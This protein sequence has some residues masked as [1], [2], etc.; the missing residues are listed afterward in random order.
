MGSGTVLPPS[1][2]RAAWIGR[3][4]ALPSKARRAGLRC[5]PRGTTPL[6]AER[7]LSLLPGAVIPP[8]VAV[9]RDDLVSRTVLRQ[10]QPLRKRSNISLTAL[11]S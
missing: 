11:V 3:R 4:Y 1:K 6:A 10:A 2:P 9:M 8:S 7:I 5:T